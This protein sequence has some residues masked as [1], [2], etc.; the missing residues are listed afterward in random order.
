MMKI[1]SIVLICIGA[2][3]S[4]GLYAQ[5]VTESEAR[6]QAAGFL[7]ERQKGV[8]DCVCTER[9]GGAPVY[10]VF[11]SEKS[12]AV[13]SADR[14]APSIL[15]YSYTQGFN[16]EELAP[17]AAMWLD[18]YRQA[19]AS[20]QG[21]EVKQSKSTQTIVKEVAPLLVSQWGQGKNYN[22]FCPQDEDGP[23]KRCV[24]GCVATALAQVMYY[25]RFPQSGEGSYSYQQEPYGE[26]AADF[27]HACYDYNAMCD[28]ST[29]INAAASRLIKDIGVAC[30]L[31]YGPNG[32]GMYNH[33]A[34]Y[35]LR[36]H[37]KYSPN[38]EYVF[39]DSTDMDWDSLIVLH[40]DKNI[41]LYY[42]GWS[43]PNIIGH[44]FV[45]DGYQLN[46][47]GDYYYHFNFGWDGNSD[48]YFY[49]GQLS[50]SGSDFNLAQ[51]IIINA[52]PDTAKY[53]YPVPELLVN[54]DT[55]SGEEGSV[56]YYAGGNIPQG[57]DYSWHIIPYA[58]TVSKME[59]SVMADLAE[60]DSLYIWSPYLNG[61]TVYTDTLL[62]IRLSYSRLPELVL[63]LVTHGAGSKSLHFSYSA[64]LPIFCTNIKFYTTTQGT[65]ED[66]SGEYNYTNYTYCR[67]KITVSSRTAL[68]VY[69]PEFKTQAGDT[70]YIYNPRTT[71]S[72]LLLALSGDCSGNRY[73]FN[74]NSIM[75]TFVTDESGTDAGWT[76]E[77]DG[78]YAD[79]K[80]QEWQEQVT[81]TP[82][83]V[84]DRA[85]LTVSDAL[86]MQ[87]QPY[88]VQI[89]DISGKVL[90]TLPLNGSTISIDMSSYAAGVYF[91]KI[92]AITKKLLKQ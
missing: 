75:L 76:M 82:N 70:L 42:A 24:T 36:T 13:V 85:E 23:N 88:P 40:L 59:I 6:S 89:C 66:G 86:W 49:T 41:P 92:G 71:P 87:L 5:P 44:G 1:K 7:G 37:F 57:A 52:Y 77:Y 31:V 58:D 14:R 55:L 3:Y 21:Q 12:Y 39:R 80:E 50:P 18:Y 79:V 2:V 90:K 68:V 28:K 30:D 9:Q 69:F 25:F 81:L 11:S 72:E 20:L 16:S 32:T 17:A 56:N 67:H 10:Y 45:C 4:I 61:F 91:L 35:A 43:V 74:T 73:V 48:G 51:E 33:K 84:Q 34:A 62:N 22:Y 15:A 27:E 64:S 63:H 8:L 65:V 38:T 47:Q 29:N 46:D 54:E 83:P 26:L 60:G 19:I 53:T 78:A